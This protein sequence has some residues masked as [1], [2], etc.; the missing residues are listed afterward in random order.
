MTVIT[1]QFTLP[2]GSPVANGTWQLKLSGDAVGFV[3]T[4]TGSSSLSLVIADSV[5]FIGTS[6]SVGFAGGTNTLIEATAGAGGML[7]TLPSPVGISGQTIKVIMMDT[8]PGSVTV[9]GTIALRANY[10]VS[11][12]GQFVWL[13][14][15]NSQ[16]VVIG[17]N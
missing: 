17:G 8:G 15:D 6:T 5:Q 11:N 14:S 16:F 7:L 3:G 1:G 10:V 9:S 12:Q 13:E 4:S 2:N